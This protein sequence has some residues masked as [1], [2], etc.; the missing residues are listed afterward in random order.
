MATLKDIAKKC[1]TSIATVSYVLNGLGDAEKISTAM[2]RKV[3]LAA[4]EIGYTKIKTVPMSNGRTVIALCFPNRQ[5]ESSCAPMMSGI[6][7]A[8]FDTP[9]PIDITI[10]PYESGK[11]QNIFPI[12][13]QSKIDAV[14]VVGAFSNDITYLQENQPSM[15]VILIN[16]N[17]PTF[18]CVT[19]DEN[20]VAFLV[21]SHAINKSNGDIA[22]VSNPNFLYGL[23]QRA[24]AFLKVCKE[25]N[26][27]ME[28]RI[29]YSKNQIDDGYQLGLE[30]VKKNILPK[31][32][33]CIYDMVGLG[34]MRA[35][36]EHGVKIGEE[37]E[38]ISTSTGMQ[39]LFEYSSPSMSVIDLKFEDVMEKSIRL[40]ISLVQKTVVAPQVITV[41][42]EIIYR[43]SSPLNSIIRNQ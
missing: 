11:L 15:P 43:A 29:F 22:L 5:L 16:R 4:K 12:F 28:N 42:P 6:S 1:G 31:V 7:K 34:I 39:E 20:E 36:N 13:E 40:A 2:Q 33:V 38:I 9:E 10:K 24:E 32:I 30:L 14:V 3:L 26:V 27:N 23:H 37:V 25:K 17:V 21:A 19:I 8:N 18:S 35:F 41:R